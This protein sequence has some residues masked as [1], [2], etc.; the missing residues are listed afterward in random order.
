MPLDGTDIGGYPKKFIQRFQPLRE[1]A[2]ANA[3]G[4]W[5]AAVA[6]C[7]GLSAAA[8]ELTASSGGMVL[9]GMLT[10]GTL[11]TTLIGSRFLAKKTISLKCT[12]PLVDPN[13]EGVVDAMAG[14]RTLHELELLLNQAREDLVELESKRQRS[15]DGGAQDRQVIRR[16]N[17]DLV[18]LSNSG[19]RMDYLALSQFGNV[20][21]SETM[22]NAL[23]DGESAKSWRQELMEL[24]RRNVE[25]CRL[26]EEQRQTTE[27]LLEEVGTWK[28]RAQNLEAAIETTLQKRGSEE[29]ARS[30]LDA[31]SSQLAAQ[32]SRLRAKITT[33]DARIAHARREL[34]ARGGDVDVEERRIA[35]AVD[36][37][38]SK[39]RREVRSEELSVKRVQGEK[40]FAES[41]THKLRVTL[42]ERA[43]ELEDLRER[44]DAEV[45]EQ[46][47]L[48]QL[49][50]E[51]K[52][53][54]N[55]MGE[56]VSLEATIVPPQKGNNRKKVGTTKQKNSHVEDLELE[57]ARATAVAEASTKRAQES[58]NAAEQR[59]KDAEKHVEKKNAELECIRA[60]FQEMSKDHA[61]LVAQLSKIEC[62]VSEKSASVEK[63]ELDVKE[64]E[65]EKIR[66]RLDIKRAEGLLP[67]PAA[68]S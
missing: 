65:R 24:R 57:V 22:E 51:T 5:V 47:S 67:P 32:A 42:Q 64:A 44:L 14:A 9:F 58:K 15:V 1:V 16:L 8:F 7:V 18:A 19:D 37:D 50:E 39:K 23:A 3:V 28:N 68:T 66:I 40:R 34:R 25:A 6:V 63:L 27:T 21:K 4:L 10:P 17:G 12:D 38:V 53:K 54:D 41:V 60:R 45:Q 48:A 29:V 13:D 2:E 31:E 26:Q 11:L 20:S 49:L 59:E 35:A 55:E 52:K 33:Y 36:S 56:G 62:A 46:A 61:M 30:S 43:K